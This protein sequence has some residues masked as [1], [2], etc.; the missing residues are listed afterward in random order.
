MRAF[1][2]TWC[3]SVLTEKAEE[4]PWSDQEDGLCCPFERASLR[5]AC[6]LHVCNSLGDEEKGT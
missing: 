4:K 3:E 6:S 2:G 1:A 5:A